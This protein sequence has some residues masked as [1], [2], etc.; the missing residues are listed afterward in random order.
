[1]NSFKVLIVEVGLV[2]ALD[3]EVKDVVGLVVISVVAVVLVVVDV[4][5]APSGSR[6]SHTKRKLSGHRVNFQILYPVVGVFNQRLF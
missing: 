4:T 5:V 1:M 6:Y 3:I 2:F